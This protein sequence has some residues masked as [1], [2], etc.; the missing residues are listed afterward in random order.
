MGRKR[1]D[2]P[3]LDTRDNGRFYAFWYDDVAKQTRRES[4]DT[5]DVAE[6]QRRFGQ[7]LQH[8]PKSTRHAGAAGVTVEQA[9]DWYDKGHITE[10]VV[11]K[12]RQRIALAN[13]KGY[14]GKTL[15]RNVGVAATEAYASHRRKAGIGDSTIRRELGA[16]GAAAAYCVKR[17]LM[18][19]DQSP[20]I[21][22]PKDVETKAP[23]FDKDSVRLIF[24]KS[25]GKLRAFCRMAYYWAARRRSV[26]SLWVA[27]IDLKHGLVDLHKPGAPVTKKRKAIVPIYPEIRRDVETLLLETDNEYL[28]GGPMDFYHPFVELCEKHG[29]RAVG[30]PDGKT[31]WP[32]MLRHSRAT[33]MLMDGEDIYKVAKLLG[34][35]VQMVEKTYGHHVPEYLHTKSNVESGT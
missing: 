25:D 12:E 4:M 21:E 32:H 11:D 3:W 18:P 20:R 34:D 35:T 24:E 1:R 15:V 22:K 10:K 14:F 13:L 6:A 5:S 17:E 28:F 27:Q 31:P 8:G 16:L 26:S 9:L 19:I 30:L 7:F 2:I 23:W 29:I 33:H